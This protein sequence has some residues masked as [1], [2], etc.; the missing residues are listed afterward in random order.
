MSIT[1]VVWAEASSAVRRDAATEAIIGLVDYDR[2][3]QTCGCTCKRRP[4]LSQL[5]GIAL[6]A[7]ITWAVY[8]WLT[9]L[10]DE[11]SADFISFAMLLRPLSLGEIYLA[12][13]G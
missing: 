6:V 2:K 4:P 7:A 3:L 5:K 10:D 8:D 13:R 11:V 1:A 12:V 9:T